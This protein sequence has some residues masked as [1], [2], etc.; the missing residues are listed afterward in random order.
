M[1]L[2]NEWRDSVVR[3]GDRQYESEDGPNKGQAFVK[4][5]QRTCMGCHYNKDTF[6][7]RCHS[8][9]AVSPNCWECHIEPKESL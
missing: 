1:D 3:H 7:D 9:M 4:S 6:C 2:L 8:P 5:L